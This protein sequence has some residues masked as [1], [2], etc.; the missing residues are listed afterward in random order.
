M[1]EKHLKEGPDVLNGD[2]IIRYQ[3]KRVNL[4]KE[5]KEKE[6]K[7]GG[8]CRGENDKN[9]NRKKNTVIILCCI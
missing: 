1:Y 3:Q 8:R 9:I 2:T 5:R 6:I 4:E 7:D